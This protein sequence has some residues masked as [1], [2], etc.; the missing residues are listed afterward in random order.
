MPSRSGEYRHVTV[1]ATG[2]GDDCQLRNFALA[3][4]LPVLALDDTHPDAGV[5]LNAH[6]AHAD[7]DD[8][9]KFTQQVEDESVAGPGHRPAGAIDGSAAVQAA[10]EVRPQ[11]GAVIR[12]VVKLGSSP[13]VR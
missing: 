8:V 3:S 2:P 11:P 7:H 6:G 12:I 13:S 5:A 1:K 10:D 4:G 9:G